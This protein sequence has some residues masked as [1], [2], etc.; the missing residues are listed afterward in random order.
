M[1]HYKN[2]GQH[3]ETYLSSITYKEYQ[4]PRKW[5]LRK[6]KIW[7]EVVLSL[8]QEFSLAHYKNPG[9]HWETYL[10]SIIYKEY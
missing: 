4:K 3:W 2:P 8:L 10:S 6:V 9:S 1:T 7:P 5:T